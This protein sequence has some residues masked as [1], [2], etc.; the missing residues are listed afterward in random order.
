MKKFL[1]G[2]IAG[3]ILGLVMWI[4]SGTFWWLP[5]GIVLGVAVV[6]LAFREE[7]KYQSRKTRDENF[8]D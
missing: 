4:A 7:P 1:P 2:L 8:R 6:P 5:A 3:A